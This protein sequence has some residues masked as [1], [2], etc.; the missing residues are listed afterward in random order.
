MMNIVVHSNEGIDA[1]VVGKE[2]E[3]RYVR[4]TAWYKK[5]AFETELPEE[6]ELYMTTKGADEFLLKSLN[7]G[8]SLASIKTYW[9]KKMDTWVAIYQKL[10]GSAED[11]VGLNMSVL[12]LDMIKEAAATVDEGDRS[13]LLLDAYA[14]MDDGEKVQYFLWGW[15]LGVGILSK[16][17]VFPPGDEYNGF[18]A[19]RGPMS[20][21]KE[22]GDIKDA[23][24]VEMR[25]KS[26]G[27]DPAPTA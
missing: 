26:S 21:I 6:R 2:S 9:T 14:K 1:F 19:F 11:Y 27:G 16:L 13:K 4:L 23:E 24:A 7:Q 5:A 8:G 18:S 12:I 17:K 3:Q 15:F 10:M 25:E 20:L 22:F